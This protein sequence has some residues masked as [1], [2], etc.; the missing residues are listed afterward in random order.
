MNGVFQYFM[1]IIG[2][3]SPRRDFFFILYLI[4]AALIHINLLNLFYGYDNQ[5]LKLI[6]SI[7]D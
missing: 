3:H 7:N 1:N 5:K 2:G 6:V 4:K